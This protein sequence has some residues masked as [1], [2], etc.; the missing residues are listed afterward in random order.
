MGNEMGRS[1]P[2]YVI[3][4]TSKTTEKEDLKLIHYR[5]AC[6]PEPRHTALRSGANVRERPSCLRP[7]RGGRRQLRT[8]KSRPRLQSTLD[9]RY[10]F[11][12]EIERL[13]RH[14]AVILLVPARFH[15]AA[16]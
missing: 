9:Q 10:I 5:P 1:R 6:A 14:P 7:G 13:P 8:L 11:R 2:W 16:V 15:D 4:A 12:S 3:A